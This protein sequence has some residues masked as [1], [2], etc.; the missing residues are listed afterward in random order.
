MYLYL[1][2]SLTNINEKDINEKMF[3]TRQND[4]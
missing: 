2:L 4:L 3:K 1:L